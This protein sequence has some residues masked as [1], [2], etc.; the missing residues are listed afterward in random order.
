VKNAR[1][2]TAQYLDLELRESPFHGVRALRLIPRDEERVFGRR[3]R[4]AHT[5]MLGP[6]G[7]S[8]GC[9]SIK[10]YNAFLQ[11]CLKH[12]I[13]RLAVVTRLE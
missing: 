9:V 12:D 1:R 7:D 11:V 13:K 3:G 10:I 5:Y 2:H 8:N 6:N 4:L